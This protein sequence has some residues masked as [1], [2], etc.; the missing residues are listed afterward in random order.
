MN[1]QFDTDYKTSDFL[2][3]TDENEQNLLFYKTE[4]SLMTLSLDTNNTIK[5]VSLLFTESM[6]IKDGLNTFCKMCC[7]FT[8]EDSEKQQT[9]LANCG[10]S[11]DYIKFTD[12]N[13]VITVG[14]YKYTVV[15]NNYGITLFCDKV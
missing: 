1:E 5:G 14:R 4:N 9:T 15:C 13:T 10:I 2:L 7:I 6:D 8:G 12:S 11:E 3:V